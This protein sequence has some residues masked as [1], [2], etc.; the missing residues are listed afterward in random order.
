MVDPLLSLL[1]VAA[2]LIAV[3]LLLAGG[4]MTM[5]GVSAVS[6]VAAHPLVGGVLVLVVIAAIF[7]L[8]GG[9]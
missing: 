3:D 6:G 4:T 8:A 9:S 2:I 1:A 5:T 7:A